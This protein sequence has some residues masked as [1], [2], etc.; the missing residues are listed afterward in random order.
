M[1]RFS[2]I[3]PTIARTSELRCLLQSLTQQGFMDYEVILVDQND[4]DRV[5]EVMVEFAGRV[6]LIRTSSPKGAC[7]A[8][9]AGLPL[10]SGEIIAFPDDDC[11][12]PPDLLKNIDQ[13]FRNHTRYSILA[14]GAV[15]EDG[16]PSGNRWVQDSCDLQP[17]NIFR[18][19]FCSALFLRSE[20]LRQVSFDEGIGPGSS[21]K[22]G[23]GDETDLVL[24]ILNS[25][26]RG[27]FDR[28]WHIVHPRRDMLSHGVSSG[29]AVTY[30]RGMGYVLRK[31]SL[32]SLWVGLLTYDVLRGV[33]I[34]LRG[35]LSA[36]SLCFAHARG[37]ME[38]F[39]VSLT[40][41]Q[42]GF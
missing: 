2:L 15:D 38:G 3:V 25:G 21:S 30:G 32:F 37:L 36:A 11:W 20:A 5:Q 10:A 28:T 40:T 9:N 23:C 35:R 22:F 6:P 39:A 8:R 26:F 31:H 18:T 4:D 41:P 16:I 42:G 7:R 34:V 27:R 1:P 33:V 19:T 12:Y 14:V 17:I 29:R 13:W 24:S